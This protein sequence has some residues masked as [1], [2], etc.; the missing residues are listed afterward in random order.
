MATAELVAGVVRGEPA[1]FTGTS[2]RGDLQE[3]LDAAVAEATGSLG[4]PAGGPPIGWRVVFAK[5]ARGGPDSLNRVA[6]DRVD[7]GDGNG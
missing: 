7:T 5:G 6:L 4:R 3:A 2:D 1:V